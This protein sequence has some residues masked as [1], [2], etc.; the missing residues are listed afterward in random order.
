MDTQNTPDTVKNDGLT[1]Y[2][3]EAVR[4]IKKRLAAAGLEPTQI[5]LEILIHPDA[6]HEK[7]S[8]LPIGPM[9]QEDANEFVP[10]PRESQLTAGEKQVLITILNN[11]A[12]YRGNIGA[13]L[14]AA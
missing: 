2:E 11:H 5:A 12:D 10:F 8:R 4:G 14:L 9:R 1:Q 13:L 3:A 7:R 6:E